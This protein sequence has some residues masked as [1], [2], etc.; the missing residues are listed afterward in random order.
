MKK[1]MKKVEKLKLSMTMAV[2]FI[3]ALF[4]TSCSNDDFFGFDDEF[5]D[6]DN[7]LEGND[8]ITYEVK[9]PLIEGHYVDFVDN[10]YVITISQKEAAKKGISKESYN[11][12]QNAIIEGNRFLATI[13]DSC[14]N[15]G[16]KVIVS[17]CIYDDVPKYYSKP[18][19]KL[20][21]EPAPLP[22]GTLQTVGQEYASQYIKLIPAPMKSVD[23]D[24]YSYAALLPIQVA[25]TES[26]KIKHVKSGVGQHVTMSVGFSVSNV[27][28]SVEYATSD[29]NGGICSWRGS[30]VNLFQQ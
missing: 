24:C 9:H 1:N 4:A 7:F 30:T 3:V 23:F 21:G 12:F 14:K 6:S 10:Q 28:G 27:P 22:S 20:F 25:I 11:D 29:S 17:T 16:C 5:K 18:R 2:C 8:I 19:T 13:I 26:W 15:T